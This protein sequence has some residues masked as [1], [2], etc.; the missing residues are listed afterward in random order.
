M[1]DQEYMLSIIIVQYFSAVLPCHLMSVCFT[2]MVIVI[3]IEP[4]NQNFNFIA[5]YIN[6]NFYTQKHL[7]NR[8]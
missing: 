5:M 6:V 7:L 2:F 3:H 8:N 4:E 1:V